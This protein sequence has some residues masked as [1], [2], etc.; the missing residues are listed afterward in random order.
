MT[1]EFNTEETVA[2]R[3]ICV[4]SIVVGSVLGGLAAWA[5]S[6]DLANNYTMGLKVSHELAQ[7]MAMAAIA[8]LALPMAQQLLDKPHALL[9]WGT[10]VAVLLTVVA[11]VMAYAE[12]QGAEIMSRKGAGDAYATAQA[13][14]EAARGEIASAKAE[15]ATITEMLP[16]AD[17]SKIYEDARAKRDAEMSEKRGATCGKNCRDA[18][19]AMETVLPRIAA[20]KAKEAA[21]ARAEAAQA[22][23]DAAQTEAKA[24]PVEVS[25]LGTMI[26]Q[27]IDVKPESAARGIALF[28]TV[29]SIVMTL[30]M[31][32]LAEHA[33]ALL[34]KGF[35][36]K[37]IAPAPAPVAANVVQ[38][39]LKKAATRKADALQKLVALIL[40]SEDGGVNCSGRFLAEEFG[41]ANSTMAKWLEEW[42][43]TGQ[44]KIAP[45]TAHK[46]RFSVA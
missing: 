29:L 39:P 41:V 45:I 16:S 42:E 25:M 2:P 5:L 36:F 32:L 14:A 9:R 19:K 30:V 28:L 8:V 10:R 34:V 20:A 38:M 27:A 7:V 15:A 17:L 21:V 37:A 31:A 23:L 35:G 3:K 13:N 46:K 43:A 33:T 26:A 11:A 1:T 24:G 40:S 44:I 4:G 22:R 6:I 18:E 12:K